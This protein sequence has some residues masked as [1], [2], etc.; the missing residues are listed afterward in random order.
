MSEA[1]KLVVSSEQ[2]LIEILYDS[3]YGFIAALII[4]SFMAYFSALGSYQMLFVNF[5][6]VVGMLIAVWFHAFSDIFCEWRHK[7]A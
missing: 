1:Q 7:D 2:K 6:S 3:V 5:M 4:A